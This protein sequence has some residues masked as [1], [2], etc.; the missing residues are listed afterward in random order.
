MFAI[1]QLCDLSKQLEDLKGL[2]SK[3]S[4]ATSENLKL[5]ENRMKNN[6]NEEISV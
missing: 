5:A 4:H 2:K 1:K 3:N 6:L